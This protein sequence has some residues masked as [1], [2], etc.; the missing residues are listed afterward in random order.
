[1]TS[2]VL[3]ET[4][5]HKKI[6][7]GF[8]CVRDKYNLKLALSWCSVN[9]KYPWELFVLNHSLMVSEIFLYLFGHIWC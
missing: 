1:M 9:C 4:K 2:G 5:N 6:I 7:L 8:I 3:S